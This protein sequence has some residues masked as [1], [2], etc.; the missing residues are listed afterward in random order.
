MITKVGIVGA[1]IMGSG[2]AQ[3]FAASGFSVL[4]HDVNSE[5]VGKGKAAI[6][7]SLAKLA[8]KGMITSTLQA[9]AIE[10]ITTTTQLDDF[11]DCDLVVEAASEDPTIKREIFLTLNRVTP[12]STIL[13]SNTSSIPIAQL[14]EATSRPALVIGMHFMNPPPLMKGVEVVRG[15]K[16]SDATAAAIIELVKK[17]GKSPVCSRDRAGF[18]ANRVLMPMIREAIVALEE[19]VAERE[20]VDRCM[21]D[22]CN[23]PLGPLALADLIGLDTCVAILNVMATGLPAERLRPPK[24][25]TEMVARGQLG[26]KSGKGFYD[27]R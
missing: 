14:A 22:C 2:I 16:T 13:A 20:D 26:R 21:V 24:L 23:F 15:E 7:K 17:L 9:S 19:G 8:A 12:A 4:L 27:Y 10:K 6:E 11:R 18:I 5:R 1:G 3:V 25:L